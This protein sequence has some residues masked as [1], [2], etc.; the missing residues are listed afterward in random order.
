MKTDKE[1]LLAFADSLD[2]Q[3]IETAPKDGERVL[4]REEDEDPFTGRYF[5]WYREDEYADESKYPD[6]WESDMEGHLNPEPTH[7]MPLPTGEAAAVMR[8]LLDLADE[9]ARMHPNKI[10]R[11]RAETAMKKTAELTNGEN[12]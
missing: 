7:W 1:T 12:R 2:W 6:H 5:K 8:E 3:P 9:F 11:E 4:L 10:F